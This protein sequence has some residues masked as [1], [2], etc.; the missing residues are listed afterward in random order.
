MIFHVHFLWRWRFPRRLVVSGVLI[1]VK[2]ICINL[3]DGL[4][5]TPAR[6]HSHLLFIGLPMFVHKSARCRDL[7]ENDAGIIFM[8]RVL[9]VNRQEINS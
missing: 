5:L 4:I 6:R 9:L 7:F 3:D 8:D 2:V 1:G